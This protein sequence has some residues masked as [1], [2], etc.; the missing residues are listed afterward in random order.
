[1]ALEKI[2]KFRASPCWHGDAL[3]F[4]SV[5]VITPPLVLDHPGTNWS[6]QGSSD[7][8]CGIVGSS[9]LILNIVNLLVKL[10]KTNQ[11]QQLPKSNYSKNSPQR[12]STSPE[13]TKDSLHATVHVMPLRI[14]VNS[15]NSTTTTTTTTTTKNNIPNIFVPLY[16]EVDFIFVNNLK[17][18]V[19][20]L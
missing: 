4:L 5:I 2:F 12:P 3:N 16:I 6:L 8:W 17:L 14:D 1:M 15:V 19:Q 13:E 11:L 10:P 18:Q 9:C 20:Q 7:M